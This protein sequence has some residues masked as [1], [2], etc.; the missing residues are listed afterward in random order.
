MLFLH[1]GLLAVSAA[2]AAV[3]A[4]GTPSNAVYLAPRH[5][6]NV[7]QTPNVRVLPSEDDLFRLSEG[8]GDA[9]DDDGGKQLRHP[10]AE[11]ARNVEIQAAADDDVS[12]VARDSEDITFSSVLASAEQRHESPQQPERKLV[13]WSV[14]GGVV[15]VV[16]GAAAL[17]VAGVIQVRRAG[18]RNMLVDS[19]PTAEVEEIVDVEDPKDDTLCDDQQEEASGTQA[20]A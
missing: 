11:K 14:V 10:T 9:E 3:C 15:G 16:V 8:L 20:S 12:T 7:K 2:V 13:F 19:P 18:A 6:V 5:H 4:L 17:V 1:R